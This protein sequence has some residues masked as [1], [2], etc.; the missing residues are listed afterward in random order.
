M[1]GG[2]RVPDEVLRLAEEVGREIA[3]RGATLVC[4]GRGGV[5]EAAARGASLAGGW[6]VGILPSYDWEEANPYL[7]VV[8]PSGLGHA[9]N[10][11]V[12]AA[13]DGVVALAGESGTLSEI[14]LARK[15]GRRVVALR[16]WEFVPGVLHA[17]D[18]A[19]AVRLALGE[20]R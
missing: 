20:S 10:A 1:V 17:R 4:G 9:R 18:P 6:T 13:S 12:V 16:A 15:L 7:G 11:V 3:R 8:V 5:M 19:E 14:G 2:S